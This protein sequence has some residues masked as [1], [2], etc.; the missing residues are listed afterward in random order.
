MTLHR[1]RDTIH[2]ECEE[3]PETTSVYPHDDFDEMIAEAKAA[4]W[5]IKIVTGRYE[6]FCPQHKHGDRLAA[7]QRLFGR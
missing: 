3:C 7:A 5:L 1:D 6:H 2:L 4:G